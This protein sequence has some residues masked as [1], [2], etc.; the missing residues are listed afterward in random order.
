[1]GVSNRS[2]GVMVAAACAAA[3]AIGVAGTGEAQAAC[4]AQMTFAICGVDGNPAH[5]PG[6]SGPRT[7]VHYRSDLHSVVTDPIG[8]RRA[9]ERALSSSISSF[10]SKCPGS[11][12]KVVGHSY[13]A[14]IAGNVRDS[15]PVRNSSYVLI[16][17]P[18]ANMGI[19][20]MAPSIPGYF[21][22][23]GPRGKAKAPTATTCRTSDVVCWA[24]NPLHD[25]VGFAN[26]VRG[27][28][29][30]EHAYKPSEVRQTPGTRIIPGPQK[31]HV[32]AVAPAP[33]PV[34][35]PSPAPAPAPAPRQQT[36]ADILPPPIAPHVPPQIK[37]IPIPRVELPKLPPLPRF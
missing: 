26:S 24:P 31:V 22:A 36:V 9:G 18:R 8:T 30:G 20:R 33:A 29:E 28:I 1:M 11:H 7:N 25:P 34:Q 10:R 12:V 27:Y 16:A 14:W 17:D 19:L 3:T 37:N 32:P 4:P 21:E 6:V 13:G 23:Q 2:L 35:R 15:K 5:V